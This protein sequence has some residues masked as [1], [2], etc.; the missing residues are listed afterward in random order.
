MLSPLVVLWLGAAAELSAHRA[1][2]AAWGKARGVHA[3]APEAAAGPGYDASLAEQVEALLEQARTEAPAAGVTSPLE[4][5]EVILLTHPELPQ[6]AW[7]FAERH[8]LEAHAAAARGGAAEQQRAGEL[9]ARANALEGLRAAAAGAAPL[10]S[11]VAPVGAPL[12][13][14]GPRPLDQ[15]YVD[16]LLASPDAVVAA[17]CHHVLLA[18]G[19][20]TVTSVWVEAT[21]GT[22]TPLADPTRACS[23]LDLAGLD[24]GTGSAP[25]PPPGVLCQRWAVA[26]RSPLG[27]T[28][29]APCQASRCGPWEPVRHPLGGAPVA[30]AGGP[31]HAGAEPDA[32]WP[33]W[34]TWS[35][36]GAGAAAATGV[37]LWQT[38]AFERPAP[39]TEFVFTGPN[40]AAYRF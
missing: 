10:P 7:L 27:G 21:P 34:L 5:A 38:G 4:R 13:L 11:D 6:A 20:A 24:A 29:L 36:L 37:V 15:V 23:A 1:D 30:A 31:P 8:R 2:I 35:L 14:S 19:A 33:A 28:E 16:G 17:G 39:S 3:V 25:R 18:R 26:R 22:E 40:A 32:P 9:A 12:R